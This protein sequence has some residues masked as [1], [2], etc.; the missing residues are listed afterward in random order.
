MSK[1]K[2]ATMKAG[3]T[4]SKVVDSGLCTGCGTCAGICPNAAVQMVKDK[5][6]GIYLP[7]LDKGSCNECGICLEACPGYGVDFKALNLEIFGKQPQDIL[8]GNY[9]GT[10]AG[11]ASDQ[12]IRYNSASGGVVTALLVFAL[13]NG[14]IDGALV[15]RMSGK[16]PLEP[17]PFIARTKEEITCACRSKYCPVPA[18]MAL[19]EILGQ[20][21]KFAVVGLPCHIHG[22]R[23]AESVDKE[24][25]Q[26][27]LLHFGLFCSATRTFQATEYILYRAGINPAGVVEFR[28]RGEGR[29]GQFVAILS[30]GKN[31]PLLY[32]EYYAQSIRSFF[33][34][35]R[36]G[37]CNDHSNE[38]SDISFGDISMP[39]FQHDAIGISSVICRSE[40][41]DR[42]LKQAASAGVIKLTEISSYSLAQSKIGSLYRKKKD[43][44]ARRN[45]F[46]LTGKST[47][48]DNA[49]LL[50]PSPASY[51]HAGFLYTEICISAKHRLWSLIGLL[52]TVLGWGSRLLN[53]VRDE[54]PAKLT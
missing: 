19:K 47:P 21:G 42:F 2:N 6:K 9:L 31:I 33:I 13:E 30:D 48:N 3:E 1:R 53:R 11:Y 35:M 37:L 8:L 34:P 5:S 10:Y 44:N 25:G 32:S 38:L 36:C 24:L 27:V 28:Y 29:P 46:R 18:N 17:Q 45:L 40:I 12:S 26:R 52:S 20:D 49:D 51:I 14:I 16:N 43:L 50:N 41:G 39:E 15:T 4:I 54:L 7:Q 23:N 22:I